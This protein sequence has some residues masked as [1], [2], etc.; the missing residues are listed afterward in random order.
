MLF[1]LLP[2]YAVQ[3]DDKNFWIAE[4]PAAL[5]TPYE[6]EGREAVVY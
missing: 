5:D 2:G 4:H 6:R 1:D 3:I